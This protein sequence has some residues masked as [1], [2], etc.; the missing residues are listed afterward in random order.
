MLQLPKV[1]YRFSAIPIIISV[2]FFNEIE[3]TILKFTCHQK[4][5]NSQQIFPLIAYRVIDHL[6]SASPRA[7]GTKKKKTSMG[8]FL[9]CHQI[10]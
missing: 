5:S 4:T 7:N 1:I 2:L 3:Q 9:A 8:P 10:F 6:R